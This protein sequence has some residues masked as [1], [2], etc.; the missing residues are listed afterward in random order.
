MAASLAS[1]SSSHGKCRLSKSVK[2]SPLQKC[3][4]SVA[5]LRVSKLSLTIPH[6]VTDE[7]C[8]NTDKYLS[9]IKC[10][11]YVSPD[12]SEDEAGKGLETCFAGKHA[13]VCRTLKCGNWETQ[14]A[15]L[16]DTS[17]SLQ[18]LSRSGLEEGRGFTVW[19]RPLTEKASY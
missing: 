7:E 8:F 1:C 3:Q 19:Q 10:S 13:Q 9:E 14:L 2:V 6:T 5:P 4:Q 16:A 11:L 17:F 18:C 12:D 15:I